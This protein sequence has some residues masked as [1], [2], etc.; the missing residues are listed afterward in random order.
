LINI[1]LSG[2]LAK[3]FSKSYCLAVN[4]VK[5]AVNALCLMIPNFKE[6]FIKYDY[7]IHSKV[8]KNKIYLEPKEIDSNL[9]VD[10][11]YIVPKITGA[12]SNTQKGVSKLIVAAAL[13]FVAGP[14]GSALA[15]AGVAAT[16]AAAVTTA[17][18]N[19]AVFMALNGIS[20]LLTPKAPKDVDSMDSYSISSEN[21]ASGSAVPLA[22]GE[23]YFDVIPVS[24]EIS[25]SGMA[26]SGGYTPTTPPVV[27]G[28]F[29]W[30][31][32]GYYNYV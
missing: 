1:V 18:T 21:S 20:T 28:G 25:S 3:K 6:E 19:V 32:P 13:F 12:K 4:S 27:P 31:P 30:T 16:T 22:Y 11:I 23:T 17:I 7:L 26:Q 2:A 5:E 8:G 24:V 15:S 9:V 10:T 14:I 29:D